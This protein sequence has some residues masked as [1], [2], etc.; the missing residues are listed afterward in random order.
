[1]AKPRIFLSSTYYDLKQIRADI[2]NFIQMM[3]YEAVRNEE[4]GIPYGKEE[5]LE[6]YCYEEIA[7]VDIVICIIGGRFGSESSKENS[8]ISQMEVKTAIKKEKHTFIFIDKNVNSEYQTYLLNKENPTNYRYVDDIRIYKFIEEIKNLTSNNNIKEFE[9]ASDITKYLREQFAGLFQ[10]YLEGEARIKE[11]EIINKLDKTAE[12]LDKLVSYLAT[13]NKEN[14]EEFNKIISINHPLVERLREILQIKY[15]FYIEGI[16]DFKSLLEA[17]G[18]SE[19]DLEDREDFF[20]MEYHKEKGTQRKIIKVNE[21]LFENEKLKF[22]KKT[23]W[24]NNDVIYEESKLPLD[25][26]DLPF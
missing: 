22:I 8:S 25:I 16:E 12:M 1:M 18:Y 6:E 2:D 13:A 10:K 11:I 9:T 5:A 7:K 20:F 15:N 26:D 21:A 3:G 4:G 17:R 14:A 23:D 19:V 24:D